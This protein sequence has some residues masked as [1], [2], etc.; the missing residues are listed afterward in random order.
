MLIKMQSCASRGWGK[1]ADRY[2]NYLSDILQLM[3]YQSML[4]KYWIIY[5]QPL[6][7]KEY[8]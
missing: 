3:I 8:G 4:I 1:E 5:I 2:Q 7:L 6:D